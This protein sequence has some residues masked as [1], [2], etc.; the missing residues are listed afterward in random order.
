MNNLQN[1]VDDLIDLPPT[2]LQDVADLLAVQC[3][4]TA[5]CLKNSISYAQQEQDQKYMD[6]YERELLW[7][8]WQKRQAEMMADQDAVH[9]GERI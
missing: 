1:L 7:R 8:D 5:E 3:P 2:K 9:Y 6:K 4:Y